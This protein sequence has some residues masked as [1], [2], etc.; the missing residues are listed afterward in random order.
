MFFVRPSIPRLGVIIGRLFLHVRDLVTKDS[1]TRLP[2]DDFCTSIL[3]ALNVTYIEIYLNTWAYVRGFQILC[4]TLEITLTPP[5]FLHHYV[6]RP[7]KKVNWL[8]L[9]SEP[10]NRLLDLYT[11]PYKHFKDDIF[12]ILLKNKM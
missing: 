9:V 1:Y 5:L 6:T 11:L 8:F 4:A 10:R 2:L 12:K 7:E 3:R